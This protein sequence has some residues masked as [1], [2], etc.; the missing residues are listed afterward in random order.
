[1]LR[2]HEIAFPKHFCWEYV[3]LM[4]DLSWLYDGNACA[5]VSLSCLPKHFCWEY[6]GLMFCHGFMMGM[7]VLRYHEI[8]LPNLFGGNMFH[9]LFKLQ[10]VA[11]IR[12]SH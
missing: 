10:S 8:A 3:G 6:V 4:L 11:R 9:M 7:L 1:M 12:V 5:D 2:Y